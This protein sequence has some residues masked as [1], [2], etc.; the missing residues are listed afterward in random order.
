MQNASK[1][2]LR[3]AKATMQSFGDLETSLAVPLPSPVAQDCFFSELWGVS[4][5]GSDRRRMNGLDHGPALTH[6]NE[7]C[8]IALING[9]RN[10]CVRTHREIL[11]IAKEMRDLLMT[12]EKI[13]EDLHSKLPA[14][15]TEAMI[16][17]SIDLI[18]QLLVM[19]EFGY[20]S[21]MF[22]GGGNLDW[23]SGTLSDCV[24]THFTASPALNNET[25]KL[26]KAFNARNL[27]HIA[28]IR[29]VWTNNLVDHLRL[30]D[31]DKAVAFFH[32]ATFLQ[33]AS[34]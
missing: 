23:R 34:K 13:K 14:T 30:M 33:L 6:Y 10:V 16:E 4:L 12:R 11:D 22:S 9:G 8:S 29:I 19:S 28:G 20:A 31:N 24:Q 7:S 15:V 32:Y 5:A 21:N 1:A 27:D 25:V 2:S 18:A 26:E 3:P 17:T